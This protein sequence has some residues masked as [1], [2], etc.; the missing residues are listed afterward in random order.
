MDY[1]PTSQGTFAH[2]LKVKAWEMLRHWND[3]IES[4]PTN[5]TGSR[6]SDYLKYSI[7]C[8]K[9]Y[10][11]PSLSRRL[12]NKNKQIRNKR[13]MH[14]INGQSPSCASTEVCQNLIN[15]SRTLKMY[16]T[17]DFTSLSKYNIQSKES[18]ISLTG[19]HAIIPYGP[20]HIWKSVG[21]NTKYWTNTK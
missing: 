16:I 21:I 17:M 9:H 14:S 8:A 6:I 20:K 10:L 1:I 11:V 5:W 7:L 18:N 12:K 15:T 3:K 13:C 2:T 4:N 19:E